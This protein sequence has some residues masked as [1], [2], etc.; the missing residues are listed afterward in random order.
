MGERIGRVGERKLMGSDKDILTGKAKA[1]HSSKAKRGIHSLLPLSG[2]CS[3]VS[4]KT[5]LHHT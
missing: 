3:A 5:R 2:G 1:A 4:R